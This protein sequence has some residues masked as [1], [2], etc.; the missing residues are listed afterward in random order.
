[1]EDEG[2]ATDA[3]EE[4]KRMRTEKRFGKVVDFKEKIM[5]YLEPIQYDIGGRDL[6]YL[7]LVQM[8]KLKHPRVSMSV[9]RSVSLQS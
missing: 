7:L 5:S 9:S 3:I 2:T 1:M 4:S 6:N 8:R